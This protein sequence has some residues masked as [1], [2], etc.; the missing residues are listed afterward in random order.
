MRAFECRR[1][2]HCCTNQLM[3]RSE[4]GQEFGLYLTP[5]EASF[6]PSDVVYPLLRRGDDVFAY[7]L[8]VDRCPN[9]RFEEGL[10]VCAIYHD[11][12][13]AC[14]AF[15]A[16]VADDGS[17]EIHLTACPCTADFA[18]DEWDMASFGNCF[19]AAR[20]QLEQAE[21]NPQATAMYVLNERAWVAL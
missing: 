15:P 2:G 6:F 8:G 12:P 14:R 3:G 1:G 20:E 16:P 10:A 18:G 11:R 21:T 4:D 13:L 5:K 9:L 7:Q 19:E 17:V